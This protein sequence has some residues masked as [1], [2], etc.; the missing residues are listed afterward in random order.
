MR[1]L[2][3][4]LLVAV[5]LGIGALALPTSV[6]GTTAYVRSYGNSMEPLLRA[7]DLAV[8][9][10]SRSYSIGDVVAYRSPRLGRVV[11]HRIVA[12]DGHAFV[13][14]GDSNG[15]PDAEHLGAEHVLGRLVLRVPRGGAALLWLGNPLH[16]VALAAGAS[17]VPGL[18]LRR[19]RRSNRQPIRGRSMNANKM[20]VGCRAAAPWVAAAGALLVLVGVVAFGRTPTRLVV[21]PVAFTHNG[22]FTYSAPASPPLYPNGPTTGDPIF[23][24][25]ADRVT[26]GFTYAVD[27][28]ATLAL[29]GT[30]RVD[31]VLSGAGGWK[32]VVPLLD[33]RPIEAGDTD[34]EVV[35][36]LPALRALGA[37]AD[38]ITGTA[39]GLHVAVAPSVDFGGTVAGLDVGGRFGPL[40]DF[41]LDATALRLVTP[42][43]DAR[44]IERSQAGT[45]DMPTSR[46]TDL[47]LPLVGRRVAVA[48]ARIVGILGGVALLLLAAAL[49]WAGRRRADGEPARIAARYGHLL[50][51]IRS[52]AHHNGPPVDVATIADLVRLAEHH[53]Q[54][55]THH[56]DTGGHTYVVCAQGRAYRY[57]NG[58]GCST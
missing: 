44:R 16:A 23:T 13:F 50:I 48:T 20:L 2:R 54:L 52:D 19:R 14:R 30:V 53:E 47:A 37:E 26:V 24:R 38:A 39:G 7:G 36:N 43:G 25:L 34:V 3:R 49:G 57:R 46:A 31:A 4:L 32:R 55:V 29:D 6:G 28:A 18:L 35:L 1:N 9:R 45:V 27:S 21:Q 41:T 12:R 33:P 42:A 11:L 56:V 22:S 40:L 51:P 58:V 5:V 17:V 10:S 8:V 15:F